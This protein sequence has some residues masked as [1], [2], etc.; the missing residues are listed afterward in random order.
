MFC[1]E[2]ISVRFVR[3]I[4]SLFFCSLPLLRLYGP[5]A[6]CVVLALSVLFLCILFALTVVQLCV[7]L[8]SVFSVSAVLFDWSVLSVLPVLSSALPICALPFALP[9]LSATS[10]N[11]NVL[12]LFCL[13]RLKTCHAGSVCY[14]PV[15]GY[16][17]L[18]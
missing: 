8:C 11:Y 12:C 16:Y 4:Y 3:S 15:V 18:I 2:E 14:V 6:L 17:G 1:C 10:V 13:L 7:L 5:F 9:V